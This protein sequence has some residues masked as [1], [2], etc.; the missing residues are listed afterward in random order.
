MSRVAQ[1]RYATRDY[2]YD[3]DSVKVHLEIWPK[4]TLNTMVRL[5]RIDAAEFRGAKKD[6]VRAREAQAALEEFLPEA[7][8]ERAIVLDILRLDKY[9]RV[10]AEVLVN[11]MNASDH[12][13]KLGVVTPYQ[14]R[15]ISVDDPFHPHCI[16][17]DVFEV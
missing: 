17:D 3:G 11:G 12:L 2:V 5:A 6:P 4:L 7:A 9:G 15:A 8:E 1:I 10:L 13:L 14:S 16:V